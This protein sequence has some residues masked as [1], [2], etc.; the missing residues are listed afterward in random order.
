MQI[1][2]QVEILI[3]GVEIYQQTHILT[4]LDKY[5]YDFILF[6][7]RIKHC[8][9]IVTIPDKEVHNVHY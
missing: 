7:L 4:N 5:N 1:Y 8:D 6:L 3:T 2:L 9:T